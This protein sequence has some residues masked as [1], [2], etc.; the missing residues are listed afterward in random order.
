[1]KFS[2]LLLPLL[3]LSV[4]FLSVTEARANSIGIDFSNLAGAAIKFDG[5]S[6]FTFQDSATTCCTGRDFQITSESGLSSL[7]GMRGNLSGT[8]T[9]GAVTTIGALSTAPVSGSGTFS[10]WDGSSSFAG[11]LQWLD[12]TQFGTGDLL[13]TSGSINLTSF[14]YTGSNTDLQQLAGSSEG[15]L[16]LSFQFGSVVSLQ[17][18][19]TTVKSTSYSGSLVAEVPEPSVIYLLMTGFLGFGWLCR[20]QAVACRQC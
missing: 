11:S 9:I 14:T 10:I 17:T 4:V 20:R 6:H 8:F 15:V 5:L 12:I 18:L 1:M 2:R 13:N 7:V 19:K 16:T 3:V